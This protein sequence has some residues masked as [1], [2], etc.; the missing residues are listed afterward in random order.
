MDSATDAQKSK[1]F[2][3]FKKQL[4]TLKTFRGRGT[5]LISVYI[6]PGYPISEVSGKL[7]EEAGAATNIKSTSTRKNV[8]GALE[9]IVSYLKTFKTPPE[10]GIAI[11]C[12]NTSEVEGRP[13]I[14]LYSIIPPVPVGV[15]FY[16]CESQFVLEPL[17]ELV[18]ARDRYGLVVLD[19]KDATVA[20]LDG[21]QIK[22]IKQIHSTAHAK[23]HK[24]GQCLQE[25]TLVQMA[26]GRIKE[27]RDV[28]AG[29]EL[30]SFNFQTQKFEPASCSSVFA[31]PGG[32]VLR[33]TTKMPT[34]EVIATK[35]HRFFCATKEG[36]V[37]K[38]ARDL[39]PGD[40]LLLAGSLS[41]VP[42]QAHLLQ[43][44][45]EL[46]V[47]DAGRRILKRTRAS[48]G[49]SQLQVAS[50]IGIQQMS[51][52]HLETGKRGSIQSL[53]KLLGFYGIGESFYEN[54]SCRGASLP[55]ALSP[56]L[57]QIL[58]YLEGDGSIERNRITLFE[59]RL[60]VAKHYRLL[61]EQT[62]GVHTSFRERMRKTGFGNRV[63]ETRGYGLAMVEF[64]RLN[65]PQA[66][67]KGAARRV[68]DRI[69]SAPNEIVSGFLRGLFD[70][71]GSV[72]TRG[73]SISMVN[74]KLI[75]EVQLLLLRF[76]INTSVLYKQTK[77]SPQYTVSFRE[78]A[79]L[80][81]FLERIG[82]T[83]LEK[84]RKLEKLLVGN[85]ATASYLNHVPFHGGFILN[86]LNGQQEIPKEIRYRYGSFF[87][88][89]RLLSKKHFIKLAEGLGKA[90]ESNREFLEKCLN[91]QAN[92]AR[93]I[94]VEQESAPSLFYDLEVPGNK[95]F[96]AQGIVVHN[97]AA[98]F[99]RLREEGIEYFYQRIGEAM[100][101]FLTVKSF[102]GV[103]VGG[104]GPV[105]ESFLKENTFNY[106]LKVLGV[107][108][109]G[110]TDE[111]GLREVVQKAEDILAQHEVV[112]ERKVLEEFMREVAKGG[113][114]NY[115]Y[116]HIRA[117]LVSGQARELLVSE[118]V[119]LFEVQLKCSKCGKEANAISTHKI[120]PG[121]EEENCSCG[122]RMRVQDDVDLVN[123][124]VGIAE[125]KGIPV[126][127]I[128]RDTAEGEEF[129]ATFN[130]MGVFL[131][132]K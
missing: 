102:K 85:E 80:Q 73:I 15:Q 120:E 88:G 70:A 112:R 83:S 6:T 36:V 100:D 25:S 62:L 87:K 128:S 79:S 42:V 10:N 69:S 47:S 96:I 101:A 124:L 132:Y 12:G 19:G 20:L 90:Q 116:D 56:Q 61:L 130:G 127:Y 28:S 58:G 117:S 122:G 57:A 109:T 24:G 98:R 64:L 38:F 23:T 48:M 95:N 45:V 3:D 82:F 131:R 68:P 106:Q 8:I 126:Q 97:S 21:K 33:I 31:R 22:V 34:T 37:E 43:P 108:D 54:V 27:I 18:D 104:P 76:G 118:G 9:R 93:V 84:T 71:E 113:L 121:T 26:D 81:A 115:G 52:S 75:R 39:A 29:D 13:D 99:G 86:K 60:Q 92:I 7:R 30:L 59:D 32:E 66:C 44:R 35:E 53:D 103:I 50:E 41:P 67:A 2:Y 49:I 17:L 119:K 91:S 14:Q 105:K 4:D 111:Y 74:Q 63:L 51:L 125:E 1:E 55:T 11:F 77:H 5:E 89:N 107:V 40:M 65:F 46:V 129:Y 114:A 72:S 94:S 78:R 16:R 110:Y 123:D